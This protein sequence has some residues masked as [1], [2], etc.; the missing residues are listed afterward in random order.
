MTIFSDKNTIRSRSVYCNIEE[1]NKI[2][3]VCVS[4]TRKWSGFW[5]EWNINCKT[6]LKICLSS[7]CAVQTRGKS[8]PLHFDARVLFFVCLLTAFYGQIWIHCSIIFL[9]LSPDFF[10]VVKRFSCGICGGFW[11]LSKILAFFQN[12]IQFL[13]KYHF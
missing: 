8:T 2:F 12:L 10:I 7:E 6:Y 11:I 4:R 1:K 13:L 3:V 9:F 5:V